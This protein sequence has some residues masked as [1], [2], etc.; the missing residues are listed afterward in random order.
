MVGG[1]GGGRCLIRSRE[2]RQHKLERSPLQMTVGLTAFVSA[3][4]VLSGCGQE[5]TSAPTGRATPSTP[6]AQP[7]QNLGSGEASPL[8][9][10]MRRDQIEGSDLGA[11]DGEKIGEIDAV[12]VDARGR[13]SHLVVKLDGPGDILVQVPLGDV[14]AGSTDGKPMLVTELTPAQLQALPAA[15]SPSS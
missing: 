8:V 3:I 12:I 13:A 2:E 5:D 4:L 6:L 10:G 7:A 1:S 9:L 11:A 15:T 14:R